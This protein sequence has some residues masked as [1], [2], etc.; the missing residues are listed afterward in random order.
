[1]F[2]IVLVFASWLA[3]TP[4]SQ[5][6]ERP[7]VP[8]DSVRVVVNGCLYGRV[9][10]TSEVRPV[11]VESG[12]DVRYLRTLRIAAKK[13]VM[14]S[15]KENDGHV[16]EVT[17]LLKK[18]DLQPRGVRVGGVVIGG[19]TPVADPTRRGLPN[20]ADQGIVMDV[21]SVTPAGGSCGPHR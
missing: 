7:K 1:M 13:D 17:G 15:V 16:V 5:E 12:P 3:S 4:A 10:R 2:P 11:D 14:K 8:K 18:S 6:Q 20:P 9:L 19:G 21:L